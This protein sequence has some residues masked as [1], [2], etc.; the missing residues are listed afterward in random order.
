MTGSP[1]TA[2]F[3]I[4]NSIGVVAP[5]FASVA[6]ADPTDTTGG[7]SLST[8]VPVPVAL[9]IVAFTGFVSLT[10]K[11]SLVS[12]RVSPTIGM[13]IVTFVELAGIVTVPVRSV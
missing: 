1:E 9:A 3:V 4:V 13:T 6:D 5:V 2:E 8:I 12:S 10:V 7:L 11:C